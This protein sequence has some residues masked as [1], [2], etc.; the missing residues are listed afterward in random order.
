M[1]YRNGRLKPISDPFIVKANGDIKYIDCRSESMQNM[2]LYRKYPAYSHIYEHYRMMQG[3]LIE[4][5][6]DSLFTHPVE[7]VKFPMDWFLAGESTI[8]DTTAYRYWRLKSST[9]RSADFAEIYFYDRDSMKR[10]SWDFIPQNIGIR[11]SMYDTQEHIRDNDPLSFLAVDNAADPIRWTGFDF[12]RPVSIS[13]VAYIRRGDGNDICPG[14]EYALYYWEAGRW[15]L[16]DRKTADNIYI[17]FENVP[18]GRLY[19]I[20]GLSRGKQN[21]TFLYEEGK[22]KW[23]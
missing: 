18:A 16:H 20:V 5:A 6:H 19:H 21:R 12:G 8:T 11:D 13:K 10:L 3:G 9:S 4:A 15:L 17:D 22:V 2:R 23:Y 14:D 1:H 7:M